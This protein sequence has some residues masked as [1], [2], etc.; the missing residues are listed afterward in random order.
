MNMEKTLMT[1]QTETYKAATGQSVPLDCIV[2]PYT[3]LHGD[4]LDLMK[5]IE[6]GSIDCAVTSPPYNM[7]LRIRNGKHCSRQIVKEISTKYENF[8]DNLPMQDYY[9][10]NKKVIAELLRICG[11][12]FYNVQF[13]T[14]N[15]SALYRLI[16]DYH[17]NM[18]EFIVWDKVNAEPAI[19][20]G[21]LN[22]RWEA[23]LVLQSKENAISRKFEHANFGRG[24]LQNLLQI[25]RGKKITGTH[26][27][28][29]PIELAETLV[30]SFAPITGTIID[31]FMGTGTTGV[32]CI[33]TGRRFIGMEKDKKYFEIAQ[34]RIEGHN[35]N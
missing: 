21:I 29:F 6:S 16:G 15:K 28:V 20:G 35:A 19:G 1:E 31:P 13:L 34:N 9:E 27:A 24:E 3:L 17:E 26:G 23:V 4:C 22:S 8:P 18:K 5:T 33:N 14:G 11:T 12:V 32:A 10:F 30:R 25:K 7:N 2:M